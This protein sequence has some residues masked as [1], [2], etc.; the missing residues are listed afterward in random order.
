DGSPSSQ[1]T[2]V[3][4]VTESA[5]ATAAP[6]ST[7]TTA[8]ASPYTQTSIR[9]TGASGRATYDVTIPQLSGGNPAVTAE[10]NQSMRAA[11]QDLIDDDKSPYD[12]FKLSNG[13][14]KGPFHIGERVISAEQ[15]TGWIAQPPGAH[16]DSLLSTVTINAETAKPITLQDAFGDLGAGLARLSQESARILPTTNVGDRYVR[17]GMAP[18]LENF[19][20]WTASPAGMLIHFGDYQVGA[21]ADGLVTITIPWSSLSD[22]LAPGMQDILSS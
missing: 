13:Y 21:Y 15:I 20:N 10:F 8:A 11:L 18:K 3:V 1:P 14:S 16:G 22:V 6:T 4:T 9:V 2:T 7:T 12:G 19:A 5:S 17:E